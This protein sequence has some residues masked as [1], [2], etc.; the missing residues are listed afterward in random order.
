MLYDQITPRPNVW[1]AN[2]SAIWE[3]AAKTGGFVDTSLS[4][5]EAWSVFKVFSIGGEERPT[6]HRDR[7]GSLMDPVVIEKGT[8]LRLLQHLK[9][10]KSSGPDDLSKA[11]DKVTHSGRKFKLERF[12]IHYTVV[13]WISNFF[14][15]RRQRVR[16]NGALSSW[17]P[18]KSGVPQGTILVPLLSLL[19]VSGFPTIA[20]SSVL[21][22]ADDIKIWR[23]IHS[24]SD[25]MVLKDDL[26][27]LVAWM[28][29]WSLK[30]NPN[31]RA[32]M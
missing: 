18:V 25:R 8:V 30:V 9:P 20:K 6:I 17:V 10:D 2:I 32:V 3:C 24:M 15:D 13:D 29:G 19:H 4:V 11:F 7:D 16:V 5:E 12:G 27:S 28:N 31:K 22:F 26:N 1:I 21:L 14:H 23:P